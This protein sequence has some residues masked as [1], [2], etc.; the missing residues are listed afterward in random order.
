VALMLVISSDMKRST[1]YSARALS[2]DGV[3]EGEERFFE[4]TSRV[5]AIV[6]S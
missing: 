6:W 4:L 2:S 5:S 3:V 1:R